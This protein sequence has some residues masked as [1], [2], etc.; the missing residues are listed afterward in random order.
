MISLSICSCIQ[1]DIFQFVLVSVLFK[2]RII[3]IQ[4][5]NFCIHFMRDQTPWTCDQDVCWPLHHNTTTPH[6]SVLLILNSWQ[7]SGQEG[8]GSGGPHPHDGLLMFESMEYFLPPSCP[9][10]WGGARHLAG[11]EV[12][13]CC[14]PLVCTW[15]HHTCHDPTLDSRSPNPQSNYLLTHPAYINSLHFLLFLLNIFILMYGYFIR[16]LNG[17]GAPFY[18]HT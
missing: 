8:A 9:A 14:H 4:I 10:P 11:Y 1:S 7:H 13:C 3:Q 18:M 5:M 16:V 12:R 15:H 17:L 2:I 6:C